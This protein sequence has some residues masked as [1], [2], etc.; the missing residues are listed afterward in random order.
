M[1][2]WGSHEVKYFFWLENYHSLFITVNFFMAFHSCFSSLWHFHF[3][4]LCFENGP[5]SLGI[6]AGGFFSNPFRCFFFGFCFFF[7]FSFPCSFSFSFSNLF[8]FSRFPFHLCFH[9]RFFLC[10]FMSLFIYMLFVSFIM[11]FFMFIFLHVYFHFVF[12]FIVCVG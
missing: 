1:S 6:A 2:W 8:F 11:S 5:W 4:F 10:F 9:V 3:S 7:P 12:V